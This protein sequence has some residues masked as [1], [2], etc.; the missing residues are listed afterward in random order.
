M[1]FLS[2]CSQCIAL[3]I[4]HIYSYN[5]AKQLGFWRDL[6]LLYWKPVMC[7]CR[8]RIGAQNDN[9]SSE[10]LILSTNTNP[11]PLISISVPYVLPNTHT[12]TRSHAHTHPSL[13]WRE[14]EECSNHLALYLEKKEIQVHAVHA[15]NWVVYGKILDEPLSSMLSNTK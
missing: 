14:D 11:S 13:V 15:T 9:V 12:L 6:I 8:C 1:S 10:H 7:T 5:Q 4:L 2:F 3:R